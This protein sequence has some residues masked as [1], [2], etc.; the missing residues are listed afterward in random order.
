[1][2]IRLLGIFFLTQSKVAYEKSIT[3]LGTFS[4]ESW[5]VLSITFGRYLFDLFDGQLQ[6]RIFTLPTDIRK[7]AKTTRTQASE[8][9]SF[10]IKQLAKSDR[11][12]SI[13]TL[14]C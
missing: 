10:S 1:V 14:R 2:L 7:K 8:F 3:T 12:E 13:F 11:Q 9:N 4:L 6:A 5:L